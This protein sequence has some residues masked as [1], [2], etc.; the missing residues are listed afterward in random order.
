MQQQG[1]EDTRLGWFDMETAEEGEVFCVNVVCANNN[2]DDATEEECVEYISVEE[3]Y[4][5]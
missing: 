5:L 3:E 4:E 2:A 1:M